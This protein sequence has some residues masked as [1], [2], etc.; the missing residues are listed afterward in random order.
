[1]FGL[2]NNNKDYAELGGEIHQD[3]KRRERTAL[4]VFSVIAIGLLNL[5]LY[6]M[7]IS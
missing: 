7:T 2:V 3:R 6:L 1:M 4:I 5:I